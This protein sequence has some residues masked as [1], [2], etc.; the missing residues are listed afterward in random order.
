METENNQSNLTP[1]G[2]SNVKRVIEALFYS[3]K[4]MK[5]EEIRKLT[6]LTKKQIYDALDFAGNHVTKETEKT[7]AMRRIPP[8][9]ILTISLNKNQRKMAERY[10][11]K[12][13]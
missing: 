1:R 11:N 7:K 8:L 3:Q 6:G 9:S 13:G 5:I 4:P 10:V 12:N 2:K